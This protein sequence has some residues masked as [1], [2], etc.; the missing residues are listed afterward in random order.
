LL[1]QKAKNN[2]R[3]GSGLESEAEAESESRSGSLEMGLNLVWGLGLS[4][5]LGL[6]LVLGC[7]PVTFKRDSREFAYPP[8]LESQINLGIYP[9]YIQDLSRI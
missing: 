1:K 4:P 5:N 7:Q 9:R 2:I 6:G 8:A 3:Q